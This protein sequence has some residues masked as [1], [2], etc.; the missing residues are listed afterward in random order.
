[1]TITQILL[2]IFVALGCVAGFLYARSRK[3]KSPAN[4]APSE[5][6]PDSSWDYKIGLPVIP[7]HHDASITFQ[8]VPATAS[9]ANSAA[10]LASYSGG[11]HTA[12]VTIE[13]DPSDRTETHG[14]VMSFGKGRLIADNTS[15]DTAVIPALAFALGGAIPKEVRKQ[16][17]L[18]FDYVNF[19]SQMSTV[20]G[21]GFQFKPAGDW[22]AMKLF[23]DGETEDDQATVYFSLNLKDGL[24]QFSMSNSDYGDPILRHLATVL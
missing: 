20:D 7:P 22:T 10:C 11:G 8:I 2:S 14:I 3:P 19:G 16:P 4:P 18:P 23:F 5:S 13:I 17:L 1:V 15:D 6:D 12:R 21:G 9:S 24:A